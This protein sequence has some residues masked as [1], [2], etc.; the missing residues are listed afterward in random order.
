MSVYCFK[1]VEML[2]PLNYGALY[3]LGKGRCS[4]GTNIYLLSSIVLVFGIGIVG[5]SFKEV[6]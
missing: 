3:A 5:L 6:D 4:L 2:L 1:K